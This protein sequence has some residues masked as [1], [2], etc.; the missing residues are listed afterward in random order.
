MENGQPISQVN[1]AQP[2]TPIPTTPKTKAV[3]VVADNVEQQV[4]DAP[5]N[6]TYL[7][8]L[9]QLSAQYDSELT[10]LEIGKASLV[11]NE[12]K[13]I[14]LPED[15][16]NYL[17]TDNEGVFF[18]PPYKGENGEPLTFTIKKGYT[19]KAFK[20]KKTGDIFYSLPKA[21]EVG[22][23]KSGCKNC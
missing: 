5:K 19:I 14:V 2:T 23:G 18:V 20:S 6:E 22:G 16:T 3:A 17:P 15:T 10:D 12:N 9:A 1:E 13:E 11:C 21:V 7:E 8:R 4:S